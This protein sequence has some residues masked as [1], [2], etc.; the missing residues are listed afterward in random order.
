MET[1]LLYDIERIT[2]TA[3]TA[4]LPLALECGWQARR[5]GPTLTDGRDT[6]TAV[7]VDIHRSGLR[8]LRRR[9]HIASPITRFVST[10]RL[11]A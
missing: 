5:L 8:A 3:N 9:F 7:A 10:V 2:F 4:L 6:I 1:A 11:A